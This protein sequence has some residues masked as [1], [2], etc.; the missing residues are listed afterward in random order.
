MLKESQSALHIVLDESLKDLLTMIISCQKDIQDLHVSQE[1]H[2]IMINDIQTTIDNQK[3]IKEQHENKIQELN[4]SIQKG[5][6]EALSLT[7]E[8]SEYKG[9]TE[10]C[11]EEIENFKMELDKLELTIKGIQEKTMDKQKQLGDFTRHLFRLECKYDNKFKEM[12]E[13]MA[14]C[15]KEIGDIKRKQHDKDVTLGKIL[16]VFSCCLVLLQ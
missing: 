16:L 11:T 10:R 8:L 14:A 15:V 2:T 3:T 13:Q 5:E 6:A 7:N 12:D 4:F 1:K 9:C